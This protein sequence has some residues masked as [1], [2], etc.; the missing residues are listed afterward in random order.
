RRFPQVV[1]RSGKWLD[2]RRLR[3]LSPRKP[4]D[5][6]P[7]RSR[8]CPSERRS[9]SAARRCRR[10]CHCF[11]E[12]PCQSRKLS[13][14]G[15]CGRGASERVGKPVLKHLRGRKILKLENFSPA[16]VF[17]NRL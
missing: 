15:R 10:R 14:L 13:V 7:K 8:Q 9:A 17:E 3:F 2:V 1:E 12:R 16:Q 4:G 6:L 11:Q 5:H